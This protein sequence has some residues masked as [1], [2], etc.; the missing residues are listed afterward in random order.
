MDTNDEEEKSLI[1]DPQK[2]K[3]IIRYQTARIW[4]QKQG[5]KRYSISMK[6]NVKKSN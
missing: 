6:N 3:A 1:Y 4:V 2:I 5:K